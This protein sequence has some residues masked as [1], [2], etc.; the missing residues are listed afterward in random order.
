MTTNEQNPTL[1]KRP[2]SIPVFS[3]YGESNQTA[4]S[5]FLHIEEL[6]TRSQIH[7]WEIQPHTHQGLFQLLFLFSGDVDVVLDG[8]PNHRAAPAVISVPAATVHGFHFHPGSEGYVLTFAQT[9]IFSRPEQ[10]QL[11]SQLLAGPLLLDT[12]A[13]TADRLKNLLGEI[14][15]EFNTP[16][17]GRAISLE[18]LVAAALVLVTRLHLGS[19]D[20]HSA[21]SG[22]IDLVHRLQVHIEKHYLSHASISFYAQEL[23][24]TESRLTRACR[25]ITGRSP[26][27]LVQNRLLLEA[28][29][30]LIYIAEPVSTLAYELGFEEPAY[31]WRFFKRHM[32]MTPTEFRERGS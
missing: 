15:E 28:R 9:R 22:Q 17:P 29:R 6:V 19:V 24:V 4:D 10:Q 13:A 31:F 3:L 20:A 12:P 16:L 11:L 8:V 26:L 27:E 21:A 5:E 2:G 7:N 30:K 25:A 14:M 18:G 1:S 23:G 32:G